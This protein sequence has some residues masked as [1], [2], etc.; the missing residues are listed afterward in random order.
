MS[1]FWVGNR[2]GAIIRSSWA[3]ASGCDNV[4]LRLWGRTTRSIRR[5]R[6]GLGDQAESGT[7]VPAAPPPETIGLIALSV[8]TFVSLIVTPLEAGN[9]D[10]ET[11][12][13]FWQID[14]IPVFGLVFVRS[15]WTSSAARLRAAEL[16]VLG[17]GV[18]MEAF[19]AHRMLGRGHQAALFAAY[20]RITI[21]LPPVVRADEV[22]MMTVLAGPSADRPRDPCIGVAGDDDVANAGL[23][24]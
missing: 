8:S 2:H 23:A 17:Y 6:G 19:D 3:L 11:L 15:R 9:R 10:W 1:I 16:A 24:G 14:A 5:T 18:A 4:L 20:G 12:T 13:F 7:A 22:R 21:I